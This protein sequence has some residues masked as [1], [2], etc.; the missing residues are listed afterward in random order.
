MRRISGWLESWGLMVLLLGGGTVTAL[1][2]NWRPW[3]VVALV[4]VL[5]TAG[6]ALAAVSAWQEVRTREIEL[7]A[8]TSDEQAARLLGEALNRCGAYLPEKTVR[9]LWDAFNG[10]PSEQKRS[11]ALAI[12]GF[13][14]DSGAIE[15]MGAGPK[16][17]AIARSFCLPVEAS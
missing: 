13:V 15:L 6:A 9:E 4:A 7:A 16:L 14:G 17:L 12:V 1:V 10:L 11:L 8:L 2:S 3:E 5:G